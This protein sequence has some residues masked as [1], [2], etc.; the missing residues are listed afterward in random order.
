VSEPSLC[1]RDVGN[2]APTQGSSATPNNEGIHV[3]DTEDEVVR[4]HC[5]LC[6]KHCEPAR[7]SA[8]C[9]D[10]VYECEG[11]PSDDTHDEN[12]YLA[13]A[14][15][16]AADLDPSHSPAG[17]NPPDLYAERIAEL[18]GLGCRPG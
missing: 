13:D 15:R 11:C 5:A 17:A 6:R 8:C 4:F 9:G 12:W 7:R 16:E 2:T 1:G 10:S 14:Q 18:G 3:T